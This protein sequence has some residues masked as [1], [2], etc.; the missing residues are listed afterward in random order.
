M[1]NGTKKHKALVKPSQNW[2]P[3]IGQLVWANGKFGHFQGWKEVRSNNWF[4][5]NLGMVTGMDGKLFTCER[6]FINPAI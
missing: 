5:I 2:T 1:Q 4:N 6:S 3:A